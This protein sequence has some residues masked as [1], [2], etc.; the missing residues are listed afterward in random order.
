M[1]QPTL[2][3]THSDCQHHSPLTTRQSILAPDRFDVVCGWGRSIQRIPRNQNYRKLMS[4]NMVRWYCMQH[5]CFNN[6]SHDDWFNVMHYFPYS[7]TLVNVCHMPQ[8]RQGK[9]MQGKV[10][11]TVYLTP[12]DGPCFM[13]DNAKLSSL[14]YW[15]YRETSLL[16]ARWVADYPMQ[17]LPSFIYLNIALGE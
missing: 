5:S 17:V 12:A 2:S 11:Q 8:K 4:M 7:M 1:N 3:S 13:F 14:S 10:A 16:Y 6:P 15:S 9:N